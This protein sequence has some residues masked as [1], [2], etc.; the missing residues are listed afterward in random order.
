[1]ERREMMKLLATLPLGGWALSHSDVADAAEHTAALLDADAPPQER[2]V[3]PQNPPQARPRAATYKPKFFA[4]LEWRTVR[5]LADIV[6]PRDAR[7][8][9]ATDAGV[10]EFMDF[11]M[12]EYPGN[13]ARM[14]DGLAWLNA[15]SRTRFGVPF[16]DAK[17]ADRIALVEDIAWPAKAKPE[18]A[19]GVR[20]FSAFRD[21]TAS[22]FFTSRIGVKDIGYMGNVPQATWTGC[23]PAAER[24]L[25]L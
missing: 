8:G 6:I 17:P 12:T 23:A 16:P 25:G 19:A 1:M 2:H 15:E 22:G 14:R 24:H 7:S 3:P 21:L 10:P 9:S 4:A 18:H 11:V 20:F 13:Q 5:T